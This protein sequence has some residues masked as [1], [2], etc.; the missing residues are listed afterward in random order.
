MKQKLILVTVSGFTVLLLFGI[1]KL[2]IGYNLSRY[3]GYYVQ[4]MPRREGVKPELAIL[5]EHLHDIDEPKNSEVYYDLDGNGSIQL[6]DKDVWIS[7]YYIDN[8]YV[9][10]NYDQD[11]WFAIDEYGQFAYY[12]SRSRFGRK[13]LTDDKYRV[14]AQAYLDKMLPLILKAQ[15]QPDMNLQ[16]LFNQKYEKRFN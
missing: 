7:Y 1:A 13:H 14:E 15:K 8:T 4:Y 6:K 3:A 16:W 10:R 5:V 9:I 12:K 11:D 2:Y